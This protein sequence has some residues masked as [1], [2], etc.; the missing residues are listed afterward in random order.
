MLWI[1]KEE[2]LLE[3]YAEE[4][5]IEEMSIKLKVNRLYMMVEIHVIPAR[6]RN[7]VVP[8]EIRLAFTEGQ[9]LACIPENSNNPKFPLN[10][11]LK[12]RFSDAPLQSQTV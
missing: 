7:R 6:E 5:N 10:N 11:F 3:D 8:G 2:H 1:G 4:D 9:I 12:T